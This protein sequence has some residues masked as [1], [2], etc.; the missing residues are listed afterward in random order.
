MYSRGMTDD[1]ARNEAADAAWRQRLEC[2]HA[3]PLW[4]P[5]LMIAYCCV[6]AA[7]MAALWLLT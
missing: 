6:G 1:P 2:D 5:K 3:S 7:M 4:T